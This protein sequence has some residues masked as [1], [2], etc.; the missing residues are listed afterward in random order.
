MI[1]SIFNYNYYNT[2][3]PYFRITP[4]S[5]R[6]TWAI[7]L[8]EAKTHLRI[9]STH[10]DDD[11]YIT[12][13]IKIAQSLVEAECSIY[14]TSQSLKAVADQ[15]PEND[16]IDL[17]IS[18]SSTTPTVKYYNE[19]NVLTT[20]VKDTDYYISNGLGVSQSLRIYPV[21]TWPST[22]DKPDAIEIVFTSGIRSTIIDD[23]P[24][25][26]LLG[27]QAMYLIIGRYFEMRQ[28]V[29]TGTMVSE[30]PLAAKH[31]MNQI[32]NITIC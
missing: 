32:K 28:D 6:V 17:G 12:E 13:L 1:N 18:S 20:L 9:V 27:K 10:T 7:T 24:G 11:T 23:N 4:E 2:Y 19:S 30:M 26:F 21:N 3:L 29:V 8:A 31:I 14:L 16:V 15:W 25:V 5:D 22:F